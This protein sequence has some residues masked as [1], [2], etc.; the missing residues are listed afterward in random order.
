LGDGFPH[1]QKDHRKVDCATCHLGAKVKPVNSDQPMAKDFPH[2]A[3]I[4]CHNFAEEF[5]KIVLGG[6]SRFCSICYMNG[7]KSSG[8]KSLW[9]GNI[10]SKNGE[11]DDLFGHEGHRMRVP[12]YVRIRPI[13][14]RA[15][16][17]YGEQF[18]AGA[19]PSCTDCHAPLM[20]AGEMAK[21]MMTE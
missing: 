2:Q 1:N 15:R 4:R 3:C 8:D 20:Q 17:T 19:A 11:F 6:T 13:S 10:A 9:Q 7:R 21:D 14:L 18:R 5:F 12:D 16:G